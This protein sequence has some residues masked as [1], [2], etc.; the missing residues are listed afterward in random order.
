MFESLY[1]NVCIIRA[2]QNTIL[3]FILTEKLW[4][5]ISFPD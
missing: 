3:L 4:K 1:L 2:E 5:M